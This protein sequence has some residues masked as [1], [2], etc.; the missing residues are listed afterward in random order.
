MSDDLRKMLEAGGIDPSSLGPFAAIVEAFDVVVQAR[1]EEGRE[2]S[3]NIPES[4]DSDVDP[5]RLYTSKQA[6][7]ILGIDDRDTVTRIDETEL[8]KRWVGPNRGALRYLGADL[9]CYATMLPP[10]DVA[11]VRDRLAAR[12][13]RT[14]PTIQ[15]M[16]ASKGRKR[17]L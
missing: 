15:A 12:L 2:G 4:P 7:G 14:A 6:A 1:I 11:L 8:P 13:N 5:W 10:L 17:L 3:V 9:L 16:P